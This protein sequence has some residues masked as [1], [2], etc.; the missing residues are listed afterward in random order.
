MNCIEMNQ[1][2]VIKDQALKHKMAMTMRYGDA[3]GS[4]SQQCEQL[5]VSTRTA[6]TAPAKRRRLIG[7]GDVREGSV[8]SEKSK[9]KGF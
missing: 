3:G 5:Q 2:I 4:L 6:Y 9:V 8:S 1:L 7:Y